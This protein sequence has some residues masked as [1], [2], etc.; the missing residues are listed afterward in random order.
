[1]Q[2]LNQE[3]YRGEVVNTG[4]ATKPPILVAK[5]RLQET[6]TYLYQSVLALENRLSLISNSEP[7]L[8]DGNKTEEKPYGLLEDINFA[9]GRLD[10]LNEKVK[11]IEK[12]LQI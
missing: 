8:E 10:S 1:M 2:E 5:E 7:K 9:C 12:N 11:S 4:L 6:I 3:R